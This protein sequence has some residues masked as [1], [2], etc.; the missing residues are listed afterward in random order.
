MTLGVVLFLG[1]YLG[2]TSYLGGVDGLPPL[3]ESYWQTPG[4]HEGPPRDK[5]RTTPLLVRKLEEAFGKDCPEARR[6]IKIEVQARGLILVSDDF[7]IMDDG[8]VRLIPL[9]LIIYGKNR[10]EDGTPEINTVRGDEA[11]VTFE[12]PIRTPSDMG[13]YHV[14]AGEIAGNIRLVNNRR[15]PFR[16]DDLSVDILQGPLYYRQSDQRIW[17]ED[18]VHLVDQQSKPQPTD[19]KGTGMVLDLLTDTSGGRAAH[20]RRQQYDTITG[21]KRVTLHSGVEMYLS[22]DARSG[23]LEGQKSDTAKK[24]PAPP[25]KGQPAQT[26]EKAQLVIKTHGPFSYDLLKD[27]ARFDIPSKRPGLLDEHVVVTRVNTPPGKGMAPKLDSLECE[28][29]ELQFRK[30]EAEVSATPPPRGKS[31]AKPS[32]QPDQASN[33]QVETAHAT[34][35]SVKLTSDGEDLKAQGDDFTYDSRTLLTVLKGK[36]MWAL[37]EGNQMTARELQ[38]RNTREGSAQSATALGPGR[39]TLLDDTKTRTRLEAHWRD[40][41]VSSKEGNFDVLHLT[42]NAAFVDKENDQDLKADELKVWLEP[43]PPGPD[44]TRTTPAKSVPPPNNGQAPKQPSRRPHHLI[45]TGHVRAQSKEFNIPDSEQLV[46]WFEDAPPSAALAAPATSTSAT[47]AAGTPAAPPRPAEGTAAEKSP[48]ASPGPAPVVEGSKP[49]ETARPAQ[50][51]KPEPRKPVDLR[52]RMVEATVLRFG[53]RTQLKQLKSQGTVHVTQPPAKPDAKGV[54]I[55]GESLLLLAFPEGNR[56]TVQGATS[57]DLADADLA[58]LEMDR[59]LILGPVVEIDQRTNEAWVNGMGALTM[60]SDTDF[61]GNKLKRTVPMTIHWERSMYFDGKFAE[62]Q[63]GIQA[64]Q[65][66]AHLACQRMQVFFDR[67]IS[68]KEG[69]KNGQRSRIKNLMCERA[70]RVEDSTSEKGVLLKYQRIYSREVN[71]D[72]ELERV[73]AFGPGEVYLF[74]HEDPAAPGSQR[75]APPGSVPAGTPRPPTAPSPPSALGASK[76]PGAPG[77]KAGDED[78]RKLTYVSF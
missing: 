54:D 50:A 4:P 41:L 1:S 63:V 76:P 45:A 62:F 22:I 60:E 55:R 58:Q 66:N 29:L 44:K 33:L 78:E 18:L 17:T 21:V 42:G 38:I 52:A 30:K 77:K 6:P 34:G 53:D 51:A 72:N 7:K 67:P 43:P 23:F 56:L 28:H 16:D 32:S 49:A 11:Y 39:L 47:T 26:A 73:W 15:T 37:K 64:V 65:E 3:P 35:R 69:E 25:V 74:Q 19:I 14:I 57:S 10:G 75:S 24:P 71:C 68:L 70:V 46:V 61:Q 59:L 31:S 2:Y 27:F 36:P 12:G 40:T 13:K 20:G 8:R 5:R 9:S 48:M